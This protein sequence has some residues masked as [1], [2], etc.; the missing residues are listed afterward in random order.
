MKNPPV[1]RSS[2]ESVVSV[3]GKGQ[4]LAVGSGTASVIAQV[5]V[6]GKTVER[7]VPVAVR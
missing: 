5:T 2:D 4:I 6:N 1:F 7:S 3:D